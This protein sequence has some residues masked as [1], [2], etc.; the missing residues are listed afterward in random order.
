MTFVSTD[1]EEFIRFLCTPPPRPRP[2]CSSYRMLTDSIIHPLELIHSIHHCSRELLNS[3]LKKECHACDRMTGERPSKRPSHRMGDPVARDPRLRSTEQRV[4]RNRWM[5]GTRSLRV[6]FS[7]PHVIQ[8]SQEIL[9]LRSGGPSEGPASSCS[10][11]PAGERS[12]AG[13]RL[14]AGESESENARAGETV[15]N[16]C[17]PAD[18]L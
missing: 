6:R 9:N 13:D 5:P 8:R 7:S 12:V 15:S 16:P 10:Q 1:C 4:T 14:D 17:C 18:R 11:A 3:V 2:R